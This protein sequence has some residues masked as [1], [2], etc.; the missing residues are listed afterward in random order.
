MKGFARLTLAP[1]ERR[2]VSFALGPQEL[3]YWSAAVRGWVRE[4]AEFDVWVGADCTAPLHA[5][6]EVTG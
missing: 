5:S 3:R 2:S 1:G 6:F 4:C